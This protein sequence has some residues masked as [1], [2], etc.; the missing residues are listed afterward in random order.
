M[1]LSKQANVKLLSRSDACCLLECLLRVLNFV[2][3]REHCFC[4]YGTCANGSSS[5]M[6][7]LGLFLSLRSHSAHMVGCTC[8]S[9]QTTHKQFRKD[10]AACFSTNI[11]KCSLVGSLCLWSNLVVA[12]FKIAMAAAVS[13][14]LRAAHEQAVPKESLFCNA[15]TAKYSSSC[16]NEVIDLEAARA[17]I[18]A[19][20]RKEDLRRYLLRWSF[21]TSILFFIWSKRRTCGAQALVCLLVRV[22]FLFECASGFGSQSSHGSVSD[23]KA[24]MN[25]RLH[26]APSSNTVTAP[27]PLVRN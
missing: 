17:L 21:Q 18:R 1:L 20:K 7:C 16:L 5:S 6:D 13:V 26:P 23:A 12:A 2:E 4:A 3:M 24:A 10:A 22:C 11:A 14:A 9:A 15:V 8:T 27:R 19:N 25:P